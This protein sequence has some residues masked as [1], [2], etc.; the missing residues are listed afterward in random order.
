MIYVNLN[1]RAKFIDSN[2]EKK[3]CKEL[4]GSKKSLSRRWSMW[5]QILN[6]ARKIYKT[7]LRDASENPYLINNGGDLD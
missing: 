4:S 7:P 5:N 3:I 6:E 1:E 2:E